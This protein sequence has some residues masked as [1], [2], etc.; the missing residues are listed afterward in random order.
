[1]NIATA[2][3][4][5]GNPSN[6]KENTNNNVQINSMNNKTSYLT[7]DKFSMATNTDMQKNTVTSHWSFL[8]DS[9]STKIIEHLL[10]TKLVILKAL[11]DIPNLKLVK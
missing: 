6:L 9:E 1:M 2:S 7:G 8:N 10:G 5:Y 3:E 4:S 11:Y